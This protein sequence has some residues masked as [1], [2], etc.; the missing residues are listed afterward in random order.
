VFPRFA[1]GHVTQDKLKVLIRFNFCLPFHSIDIEE[2]NFAALLAKSVNNGSSKAFRPAYYPCQLCEVT[3]TLA[4]REDKPVTMTTRGSEGDMLDEN[5]FL[6][7]RRCELTFFLQV[8]IYLSS[9]NSDSGA[10]R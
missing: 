4:W 5:G 10:R 7:K 2:N 8:Q 1:E 6:S 9:E 3:I